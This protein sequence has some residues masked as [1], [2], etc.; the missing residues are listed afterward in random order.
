M[1]SS[2]SPS[3]TKSLPPPSPLF[4]GQSLPTPTE[5]STFT[6]H[7]FGSCVDV[8]YDEDSGLWSSGHD[9]TVRAWTGASSGVV[10]EKAVLEGPIYC[11]SVLRGSLRVVCGGG[12]NEWGF[13]EFSVPA[14][15]LV[16]RCVALNTAVLCA[17][18]TAGPNDAGLDAVVVGLAD[19]TMRVWAVGGSFGAAAGSP[20]PAFSAPGPGRGKEVLAIT[21]H[22]KGVRCLSQMVGTRVWSGSC[23]TTVKMIDCATGQTVAGVSK[24]HIKEVS[25]VEGGAFLA[26]SGSI[27][28]TVRM[29]DTRDPAMQ[30]ARVE[31]PAAVLSVARDQAH[32]F[33]V[34]AKDGS[35]VIRD[36]RMIAEPISV[37]PV[38]HAKGVTSLAFSPKGDVLAS[39]GNDKVVREWRVK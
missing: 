39:C 5:I 30:T 37:I 24:G 19:G 13:G 31:S 28:K 23:D 3:I 22:N 29:W 7:S 10:L 21:A 9:G 1:A 25:V 20:G 14:L 18:T 2:S 16:G 26:V 32:V 33:A 17:A 6:G 15:D 8:H 35:V 38:A 34:G 12:F 36:E 11:F 4:T 27:D